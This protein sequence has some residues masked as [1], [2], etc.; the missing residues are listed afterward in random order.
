MVCV[1]A[2]MFSRTTVL[3]NRQVGEELLLTF[4]NMSDL[5]KLFLVCLTE[6]L[7]LGAVLLV[8]PQGAA[9][10]RKKRVG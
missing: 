1:H 10:D 7:C 6:H 8:T 5:L 3:S 4:L 2:T 9:K